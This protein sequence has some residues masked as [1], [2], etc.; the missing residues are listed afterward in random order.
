M[1]LR[2][3]KIVSI[4]SCKNKW[5]KNRRSKFSDTVIFVTITMKLLAVVTSSSIYHGCS[6]QKTFW[7][8]NFTP[9]KM[10]SFWRHNV[11]KHR[12]IKNGEQYI[13]LGIYL[14]LDFLDKREV[15]SSESSYYYVLISG[16]DRTTS[17]S[18]S[19]KSPNLKKIQELPLLILLTNISGNHSRIFII[20]LV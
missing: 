1:F 9:V 7:E 8:E 3:C 12:E 5:S 17:L 14:M 4:N 18:L 20:Y 6:T 16:K 2:T 10:T 15:S 13:V 11:R 19:T